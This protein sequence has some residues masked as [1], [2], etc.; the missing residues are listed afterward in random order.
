MT[1]ES[2][3]RR[4]ISRRAVLAGGAAGLALAGGITHASPRAAALVR[5][6]GTLPS[7]IQIGDVTTDRAVLWARSDRTG[8][9]IARVSDGTRHGAR[10][11]VGPW[12]TAT[13]DHTAKIG[14]ERLAPGREYTVSIGFEDADGAR[15]QMVK[16]SFSTAR[17]RGET[18]FVWTGDTAGQGWGINPDI[19]GMPGYAAM[20][21]TR[22]DFLIHSGDNIYADGPISAQVTEKDGQVWRNVVTEEVAKVAET[23]TE[24]RGRYRYNQSDRN[25]REMYAHVPVI[26][27]W[28][29]HET[30]NNWYPG[31]VLDLPAYTQERR[32]DVLAARARRAFG[33]NMPIA[34]GYLR[35][36]SGWYTWTD[37]R[38]RVR[39]RRKGEVPE[40]SRIYRKI[41]R[42]RHLDV[43]CLDMRT[44]RGDNPTAATTN[45]VA[46]LGEEQV[47]WLLREL[48]TSTATWKVIAADMPL[49]LIV[50]DGTGAEAV[51]DGRQ[52]GVGG[53]EHEL[54]RVLSGIK[55]R[56]IRNVVWLTADVHYTAAHHYD[57]ARAVFTDFDP[58]YEFVAGAIHAGSF[59][60]NEFDATFGPKALFTKSGDYPGQSPR[61]GKNQ[62]FGHVTISGDGLFHVSLRDATGETLYRKTLE[63]HER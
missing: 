33:E 15:S 30:T 22:P 18:T 4:D 54:G 43:F 38:D 47:R 52:T 46:I 6:R 1:S 2:P 35:H 41:S 9:M 40:P 10:E 39:P 36:R 11:I 48:E 28:D 25:V 19:G 53:R 17:H 42:G 56:R 50:P 55:K 21:E 23:L 58:F 14:L 57:P 20:A 60:P 51:S 29:D 13:T 34:D 44:H 63:P 32:V 59:G 16:G 37:R 26:A 3:V 61:T 12:A 27:Q 5:S 62:F 49:G 45:P 24:F 31:E 8:R 7:G